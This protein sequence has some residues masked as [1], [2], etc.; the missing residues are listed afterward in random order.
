MDQ[1]NALFVWYPFFG[2]PTAIVG[3][4]IWW[5]Y[6]S[7][8]QLY[9]W[10]WG[11]LFLPFFVWALMSAI[12]M[13]G[14]SLANLVEL[15]Y[16]SAITIVVMLVRVRM[17]LTTPNNGNNISKMAMLVSAVAGLALWGIVPPMAE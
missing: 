4:L 5:R 11:Q 8:A 3:F 10:D 1:L 17:A 6:Q 15:G 16:L 2:L 7:R 12:D 13:R 14:K 9:V